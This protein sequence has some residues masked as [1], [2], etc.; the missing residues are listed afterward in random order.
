[1]STIEGGM[2][3]TKDPEIGHMLRIVRANGWDRNLP[4]FM[5]SHL[6]ASNNIKSEFDAKYTFY[7]LGYNLRPTEITGFLGLSQLKLLKENVNRREKIYLTLEECAR[8]NPDFIYMDHN[9][10]SKLSSFA[11][12]VI[13]KD[14]RMRG[15]YMHKFNKAE[16]EIRPVIAGN[17]QKQ[18]FYQKYVG[19][20]Y[21]LPNAER[22]DRCGF[23]CGAYPD[24]TLDDIDTIEDC[25]RVQK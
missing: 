14:E 4:E 5:Q 10:I 6:R 22:I 15:V 11:F 25:L 23:Y 7:D 17:I 18:P 1:M 19:T 8:E 12:P 21:N 20:N 3:C 24:L 16:I 13:L 9:H 2:V